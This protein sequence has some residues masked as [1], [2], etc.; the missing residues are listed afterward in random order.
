MVFTPSSRPSASPHTT[1]HTPR[2]T[3]HKPH[4]THMH[5]RKSTQRR[6]TSREMATRWLPN[7]PRLLATRRYEPTAVRQI[8]SDTP[9]GGSWTSSIYTSE[10][11]LPITPTPIKRRKR[12]F[13]LSL[14]YTLSGRAGSVRGDGVGDRGRVSP[15]PPAAPDL[16]TPIMRRFHSLLP[17]VPAP[18]AHLRPRL[19]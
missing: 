12:S 3:H 2:T 17:P 6:P 16:H 8:S 15:L 1:H 14:N 10:D 13:L 11:G 5:K 18:T 19:R 9:A 7:Q 4:T